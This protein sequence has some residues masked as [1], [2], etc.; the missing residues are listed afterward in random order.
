MTIRNVG[1]GL[2]TSIMI[3]KHCRVEKYDVEGSFKING[4]YPDGDELGKI[5]E[6]DIM[7]CACKLKTVEVLVIFISVGKI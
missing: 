4:I 5:P 2:K 7:A 3:Q 6:K 1:F